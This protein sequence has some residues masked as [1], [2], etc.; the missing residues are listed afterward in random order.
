[1]PRSAAFHG[2]GKLKG[3]ERAALLPFFPPCNFLVILCW[4]I[5]GSDV[6]V[7][8]VQIHGSV[9]HRCL[10]ILFGFIFTYR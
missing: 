8:A 3:Q 9:M 7:S 2:V 6:I 4:D 1:M 5:V 10:S